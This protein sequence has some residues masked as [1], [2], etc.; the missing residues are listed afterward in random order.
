[1]T[2]CCK[3]RE[4]RWRI[5]TADLLFVFFTCAI[6][7][8]ATMR[9]MDDPGLGWHLRYA[10][11]MI[12][13]GGFVYQEAFCFPSAGEKVVMRAWLS[14][15]AIRAAYG[16]GGLN[17]I[18]LLTCLVLAVT[19]RCIYCRLRCDGAH[20]SLAA[21]ATY[22][23]AMG[24]APSYVARPNVVSFLGVWLVADLC[25]RFHAGKVS[26]HQLWWLV[27]IML[28]WTNMH[29]GFLAGIILIAIAWAVEAALTL[30]SL[31]ETTRVAARQRFVWLTLVGGT[32]SLATLVNPNGIGL[33]LWSFTAITD[34]FIQSNTTTEW[35]P[36]NF[37]EPGWFPIELLILLLPLL[38]ATCR[39]RVNWV[40]LMMTVVWLHF[41]LTS[42]RYSTLWVVIAI[43]TLCELTR[44]NGW[45]TAIMDRFKNG[46]SA[47]LQAM[48]I[49]Q[50][51]ARPHYQIASWTFAAIALFVAPW[52]P[53]VANHNQ[54]NLP[55]ASLDRFLELNQ[56]ERAFHSIN[57]GGYLTWH[58]WDRPTR[59]Q[60]WIDDRI[61]VHGTEDT[62]RYFE[63]LSGNPG[64]QSTLD[65]AGVDM[66]CVPREAGLVREVERESSCWR[67]L[68]S[69]ERVI[70]FVREQAAKRNS[71]VGK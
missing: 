51:I 30:G 45:L 5:G 6:M 40:G 13:Q 42:R 39:R 37:K 47:D 41:A 24:M 57:W 22:L 70:A 48:F 55:T 38:A 12:E 11:Q 43:P 54:Q 18:A 69:D 35:L 68:F 63:T 21:L 62:Q 50:P 9:M 66:I 61:D 46:L 16:W 3:P 31:D 56:G 7:Q 4:N 14:D 8:S 10:D 65:S 25:Q 67:K 28:L 58:G 27:P 49:S 52:L 32:A 44:Q 19:L 17:G 1:M 71:L 36:P 29:G 34:P 15:F 26:R 60:T 59:F 64:W 23:A 33:H 2:A 53:A 20:W